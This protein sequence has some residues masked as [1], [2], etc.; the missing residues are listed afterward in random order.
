[1]ALFPVF[2]WQLPIRNGREKTCRIGYR[3]V[4]GTRAILLS[5][6][7]EDGPRMT[8]NI[9][10]IVKKTAGPVK[11]KKGYDDVEDVGSTEDAT[12]TFKKPAKKSDETTTTTTHKKEEKK[13]IAPKKTV[14]QEASDGGGGVGSSLEPA[15]GKVAKTP[16]S[17]RKSPSKE[18]GKKE[19]GCCCSLL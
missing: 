3:R 11:K 12:E 4:L 2:L 16:H 9:E 19:K 14:A 7:V 18:G 15:P 5:A 1:M 13:E 10:D 17:H 8:T 6:Q